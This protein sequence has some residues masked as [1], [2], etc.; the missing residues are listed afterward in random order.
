VKVLVIEDTQEV[1]DIITLCLS[2]RWPDSNVITAQSGM[3]G[4]S[5]FKSD[6]PD[7]VLLDL[8][9]PDIDGMDVLEQIRKSSAVPI[10]IV[11]GRGEEKSRVKGLEGGADDYIVKPF[12]HNEL[13]ARVR[14]VMCRVARKSA[15]SDDGLVKGSGITIDFA[16]HILKVDGQ[17][18]SLAPTEWNL[19]AH[20]AGREGK[21][22]T[23]K[24]LAESV[25]GVEQMD[26]AAIKMAVRRLRL[27]LG[28][29]SVPPKIIRSHRGVGYSFE[30]GNEQPPAPP[31]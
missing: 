30:L 28:D 22:A 8:G 14:A 31:E 20:L 23:H 16:G 1:L 11:T 12:S 4:L 26:P 3:T 15:A 10:I 25:W 29:D 19:L 18:V 2:V 24:D 6:N 13:L 9:L 27:K 17:E 7:L 5:H 21:V